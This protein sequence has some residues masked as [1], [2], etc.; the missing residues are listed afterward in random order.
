MRPTYSL[1]GKAWLTYKILTPPTVKVCADRWFKRCLEHI[2]QWFNT[3]TQPPDTRFTWTIKKGKHAPGERHANIRRYYLQCCLIKITRLVSLWKIRCVYLPSVCSGFSLVISLSKF[4]NKWDKMSM[5]PKSMRVGMRWVPLA[6]LVQCLVITRSHCRVWLFTS[7]VM[8]VLIWDWCKMRHH[9]KLRCPWPA[10]QLV[11]DYWPS[12]FVGSQTKHWFC[13]DQK[14]DT[15]NQTTR[16]TTKW[17]SSLIQW[18]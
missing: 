9:V 13:G 4:P 7:K 10:S 5:M 2:S 12:L 3:R 17:G 6:S 15:T 8:K 1:K 18:Q 11:V 16:D 14:R